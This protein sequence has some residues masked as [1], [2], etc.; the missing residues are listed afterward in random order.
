MSPIL[1]NQFDNDV[2]L[3]SPGGLP[4]LTNVLAASMLTG[5]CLDNL[6]NKKRKRMTELK[7]ETIPLNDVRRSYPR[8]FATMMNRCQTEDMAARLAAIADSQHFTFV[9]HNT[10]LHDACAPKYREIRGIDA[11][12]RF[13][14]VFFQ[15]TPDSIFLMKDHQFYKRSNS[16]Q[17]H[18]SFELSGSIIYQMIVSNAAVS[19]NSIQGLAM[20]ASGPPAPSAQDRDSRSASPELEEPETECPNL[21]SSSS[22]EVVGLDAL[23][24]VASELFAAGAAAEAEGRK[25]M[26]M[27]MPVMRKERR[28]I[29]GNTLMVNSRVSV[30]GT[31]MFPVPGPQGT[32]VANTAIS[33]S[34]MICDKET[35]FT[36]GDKL[37]DSGNPLGLG[38][39]G[40]LNYAC[41]GTVIFHITPSKR[42]E[43]VELVYTIDPTAPS[44]MSRRAPSGE[45]F[46]M[47]PVVNSYDSSEG[48]PTLLP[49][50]GLVGASATAH[51]SQ[52]FYATYGPLAFGG[53]V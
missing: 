23:A 24:H 38:P 31:A 9:F 48:L 37:S 34:K 27:P 51:Y 13:L 15:T 39:D 20:T 36:L 33:N 19:V 29:V 46:A 45:L 14:G 47:P 6:K 22:E 5:A 49:S 44:V 43:R 41:S 30:D 1:S 18:C 11:T 21:L 7:T 3:S 53:G 42:V 35:V 40:E 50:G 25:R 52:S 4:C 17:I 16:S 26:P 10:G 28:V 32:A 2:K 12:A 8:I